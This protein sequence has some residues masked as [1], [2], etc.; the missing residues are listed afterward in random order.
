MRFTNNKKVLSRKLRK[1]QTEVERLFWVKVRNR[2]IEGLKFRRQHQLGI[3]I[4]DFV[5]LERK[6]IVELDGGQHNDEQQRDKDSQRTSYL[7]GLGFEIIRFWNNE[8]IENLPDVLEKIYQVCIS[9]HPDP[10][11]KGEGDKLETRES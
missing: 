9:P 2:Q 6:L 11:P 5:C 4:V 1:H 10:L 3:Y 7:E 8:V